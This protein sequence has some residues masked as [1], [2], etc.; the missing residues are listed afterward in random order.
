MKS[1]KEQG[2]DVISRVVGGASA[3]ATR[4]HRQSLLLNDILK[5]ET[6]GDRLARLYKEVNI[7]SSL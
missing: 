1:F 4:T 2:Y 6:L 7:L 5:G 3:G